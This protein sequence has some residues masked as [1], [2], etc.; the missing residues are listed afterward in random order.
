[1]KKNVV[2]KDYQK[3]ISLIKKYNQFYYDKNKPLI[4]DHEYDLIKKEI[5]KLERKYF[6]L[7]I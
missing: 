7:T 1:M 2:K 4:L 5:L 3:K 6:F